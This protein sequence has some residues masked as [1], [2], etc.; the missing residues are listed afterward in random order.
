MCI[1]LL[2]KNLNLGLAPRPQ[3]PSS[4]YTYGMTIIPR[5]VL[6][7]PFKLNMK[8]KHNM[9]KLIKHLMKTYIY[10]YINYIL[11]NKK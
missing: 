10:I 7:K 2:P 4:T 6:V 5:C 8:S 11:T 1:K 3:H 9:L